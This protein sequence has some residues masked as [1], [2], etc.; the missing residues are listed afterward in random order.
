[1]N[2]TNE[3]VQVQSFQSNN[4]MFQCQLST[5]YL[6]LDY[7]W[8]FVERGVELTVKRFRRYRQ[9][10]RFGDVQVTS[11]HCLLFTVYYLQKMFYAVYKSADP[12]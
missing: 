6:D 9:R 10:W 3:T 2:E 8:T 5:T 7:D 1:M 11:A 12:V 4:P